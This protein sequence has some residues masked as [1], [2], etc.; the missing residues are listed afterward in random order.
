MSRDPE[1]LCGAVLERL[2]SGVLVV[3]VQLVVRYLNPWLAAALGPLA[4]GLQGRCLAE[5]L[6]ELADGRL[7]GAVRQALD[8]SLPS[9]LSPGLNR[10]PLPLYGEAAGGVARP[11]AQSVQVQPLSLSGERFCLVTVADVSAMMRREGLLR[12]Q[13]QRL[14]SLSLT[15]EL[16]GIPNRRRLNQFLEAELPRAQR[17]A[18]PLAVIL[19][20]IDHFK[21]YNDT[22]GHI[23]GDACLVEVVDALVAQVRHPGDLLARY[24]GEE[25]CVVLGGQGADQAAVAAERL[26]A[27]VESLRLP[28][29]DSSVG[30]HVTIS[31][32]AAVLEAGRRSS[33][34]A[35]LLKADRAL[36]EAKQGGRNRWVVQGKTDSM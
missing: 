30:P 10:R 2:G 11:L 12:E 29:P 22:L 33:A 7:L 18:A 17:A 34:T 1:G 16:T 5:A 13:A 19:L 26:R 8:A 28:H 27:C 3:D 9:V 25:F 20:D 15:D 21:A 35:L 6:P 4:E 14:S 24:G 23:A 36:F 31:L 32:G